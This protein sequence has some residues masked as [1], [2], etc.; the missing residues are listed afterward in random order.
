[1]ACLL[2]APV[3]P[4]ARLMP[5]NSR[6][7]RG[8]MSLCM[9]WVGVPYCRSLARIGRNSRPRLMIFAYGSHRD[10]YATAAQS[11]W[12][13]CAGRISACYR[14]RP[15]E[16]KK[17]VCNTL[18]NLA[19]ARTVSSERYD[20]RPIRYAA[21]LAGL[22]SN[23]ILQLSRAGLELDAV[24]LPRFARV[25]LRRNANTRKT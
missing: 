7:G 9:V 22:A 13:D 1:M 18:R 14:L 11:D 3:K 21:D 2:A 12:R 17:S 23:A 4:T 20:N 6:K 24:N 19:S 25:S 8:L 15:C 10:R 5:I 16:L